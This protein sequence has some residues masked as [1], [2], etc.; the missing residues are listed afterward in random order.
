MAKTTVSLNHFFIELFPPHLKWFQFAFCL[1]IYFQENFPQQT[2]LKSKQL[3]I[4]LLKAYHV[5]FTKLGFRKREDC[6]ITVHSKQKQETHLKTEQMEIWCWRQCR[7]HVEK[8]YTVRS[9]K[10]FM[11]LFYA[12]AARSSVFFLF[13]FLSL[14]CQ[15]KLKNLEIWIF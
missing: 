9:Y 10:F 12:F 8:A 14:F 2:Q 1:R 6:T 15:E 7:V 4:H 11:A 13:L 3:R 5:P